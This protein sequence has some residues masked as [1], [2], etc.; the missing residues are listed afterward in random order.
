MEASRRLSVKLATCL[1]SE[2]QIRTVSTAQWREWDNK[3]L[4]ASGMA[5]TGSV[6]EAFVGSLSGSI[7]SMH[8][9]ETPMQTDQ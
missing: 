2:T 4:L 6:D 9:R 3:R 7:G 8:S 1:P 5:S